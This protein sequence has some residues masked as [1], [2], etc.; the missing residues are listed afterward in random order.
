MVNDANAMNLDFGL[1]FDW[2][3]ESVDMEVRMNVNK[4]T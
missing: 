1:N 3:K 4:P 2:N